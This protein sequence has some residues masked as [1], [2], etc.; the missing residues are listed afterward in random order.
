MVLT[1]LIFL[2]LEGVRAFH[3]IDSSELSPLRA[4][5]GHI[6]FNLV[7]LNHGFFLL[8]RVCAVI[9]TMNNEVNPTLKAEHARYA[10]TQEFRI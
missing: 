2:Q 3:V 9:V 6:R 10:S 8:V 7:G 4:D 5:D 1:A